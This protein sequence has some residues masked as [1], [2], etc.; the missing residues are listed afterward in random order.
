MK[1]AT[2]SP[3]YLAVDFD[4]VL[5]H[6]HAGPKRT[7]LFDPAAGV[8]VFR[9]LLNSR[10]AI[11]Q[12]DDPFMDADGQLF[13]R[14]SHL[15]E[16]LEQL[17]QLRVVLSTSWRNAIPSS[18]LSQ[19]LSS[20]VRARVDGALAPSMAEAKENGVRGDLME[21]WLRQHDRAGAAWIALDDQPRHYSN[22]SNVLVKTHW[23]GMTT[24]TVDAALDK[25]SR[26]YNTGAA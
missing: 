21:T 16:L 12:T 3:S 26:T 14:E 9:S 24:F 7:D 11:E 8:K 6:H 22:H 13:D 2:V 18:H 4:G 17:P 10:L 15:L 19:F 5:H 23:R 20:K 25:L 1:M